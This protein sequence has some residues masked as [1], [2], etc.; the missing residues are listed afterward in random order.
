MLPFMVAFILSFDT[1]GQCSSYALEVQG[2]A[3]CLGNT[4]NMTAYDH[5]GYASFF[6]WYK[7]YPAGN[8]GY[9][10]Q[11]PS[12]S[13]AGYYSTTLTSTTTFGVSFYNSSGGCESGKKEITISPSST[14]TASAR[15]YSCTYG[16]ATIRAT[17][18]SSISRYYLYIKQGN[19]YNQIGSNTTGEFELTN[20][21]ESTP[22]TYPEP[23][24]YYVRGKNSSGCYSHYSNVPIHILRPHAP[25]VSGTTNICS[26]SS[27][28]LTASGGSNG[29]YRWYKGTQLISGATGNQYNTDALV[30]STDYYVTY[31]VQ[32]Y[33][34][35]DDEIWCE[36]PKKRVPVTIQSSTPP[37]PLNKTVC[38]SANVTL[39][40]N[41]STEF[42]QYQWYDQNNNLLDATSLNSFSTSSANLT[43]YKVKVQNSYGC[44]SG[45]SV[46]ANIT[47]KL[48]HLPILSQGNACGGPWSTVN[49]N[50]SYPYSTDGDYY[51]EWY[52]TAT[53]QTAEHVLLITQNDFWGSYTTPPLEQD[54]EYWVAIRDPSAGYNCRT[55]RVSIVAQIGSKPTVSATGYSC[56]NGT[57]HITT[58][59]S[60]DVAT[61][62][63]YEG[64]G[65]DFRSIAINS[66]GDFTVT[67]FYQN[68]GNDH[69]EPSIYYVQGEAGSGCYTDYSNVRLHVLRGISTIT[70]NTEVC[71][72]SSTTLTASGGGADGTYQ[73]YMGS[74][75]IPGATNAQFTTGL[76][77][78]DMDYY[79][80]FEQQVLVGNNIFC[81]SPKR[82]VSISSLIST[83]PE[84]TGLVNRC[85]VGTVAL[86][87]QGEYASVQWYNSAG[88]PISGAT[89][90]NLSI[91]INELDVLGLYKVKGTYSNGCVSDFSE[92]MVTAV[93]NCENFVHEELVRIPGITEVSLVGGLPVD[94][95]SDTWTYLDDLGRPL[96]KV[97]QQ[98]SPSKKDIVEPITYDALGRQ[99]IE[100][101]S[102]S[103]TATTATP[104]YLHTGALTKQAGFYQNAD[105]VAQDTKPWAEKIF[106]PSPLNRVLQQGAAGT[107]WQPH[108]NAAVTTD[109]VIHYSYEVNSGND[110]V[111]LWTID[112]ADQ[113]KA[114]GYYPTGQLTKTVTTDEEGR[115][116][117]EFTDKKENVILKRVQAVVSPSSGVYVLGQWAD[118]YYVFDD[119]GNLRYVFPPE[120]VLEIGAPVTFPYTPGTG[121][122]DRWAFLYTYDGRRRMVEKQVPGAKPV[123][124]V[125]DNRDRLVLTQDGNQ[126]N[127]DQW[128]F[129]KYDVLNRPVATGIYA[130]AVHTT[131]QTMRDWVNQY[132]NNLTTGRAWF[133]SR[134]SVVHGYDNK[135]F[136]QLTDVN[137][138]LVITYYDDYTFPHA[139]SYSFLPSLDHTSAFITV[140]GQVTGIKTKVLGTGNEWME[141]VTYYDDRY[142]VIQS[143]NENLLNTTDIVTNRYDFVGN[144]VATE[145]RHNNHSII[146]TFDY[147]HTGRL[148]DTWHELKKNGISQGRV[149]LAR[150]V[151][152]ELGELVE[153][154][155]HSEDE[156][157]FRQSVDY[158]YNIRGWLTSINN[159]QLTIDAAINDDTDD[160]WG[161]ELGYNNSLSG[162]VST[163]AY[164]GNISAIK[165]SNEPG[166]GQRAY[167]Y[168]YDP[169]NRLEK[170][171]HLV[172]GSANNSDYDVN[173]GTPTIKGYDLNGNIKY[174]TRNDGNGTMDELTYTYSGNILQR[175]EDAIGGAKGFVNGHTGTD[176]NGDYR[177]DDNGN[178]TRDQNKDITG[179]DYN[180]LNLPK[181]VTKADGSYLS[182]L[183][184]ASGVKL[185]QEVY[186]TV[187]T[188]I[189][190]TD[191][192]GEFIYENNELQL[193]QHEEGRIVPDATTGNFDYQYHLKDH[194]G[195]V[196][197]T[198]TT[199][200]KEIIFE[201]NYENDP[202]NVDDIAIFE[203]VSVL[204]MEEFNHTEGTYANSTPYSN[205][206]VLKSSPNHQ[207]GSAI[208]LPVGKGDKI[209]CEVFAKYVNATADPGVPVIGLAAALVNAFTGSAKGLTDNGVGTI[210]GN[211]SSGPLIGSTG[212]PYNNSAAPKAFLNLIFL[213]DAE[214]IDLVKDV[215]FAYDQIA[216]DADETVV[217]D[218]VKDPFDLLQ[219]TD[220]EA[221]GNG[222]VLI[223]VSNEGSLSNVFF[224]DLEIRVN[225][226]VVIQ[227]DDYYPFGLSFDDGY[228]RVTSLK[229]DFTFNGKELQDEL[230]LGWMDYGARMYFPEIGRFPV[231]DRFSEKYLDLTPYQY[232]VNNPVKYI[233]INGDSVWI[234]TNQIV[235]AGIPIARH[236]FLRVKTDKVDKIMELGGPENTRTGI[237]SIA[238]YSKNNLDG[239]SGVEEGI[240]IRPEN[241]P[242]GD[243][244]FENSILEYF[245]FFQQRVI[246]EDDNTDYPN[247]PDYD[248]LGPNSNGF[249]KSLIELS[250]G[251]AELPWSAIGQ[252]DKSEY[253]SVVRKQKLEEVENKMKRLD[254][255]IKDVQKKVNTL[256]EQ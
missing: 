207:I 193:I 188:R 156:I 18:P 100:Y 225:E 240:I 189:K 167:S 182:Y 98:S 140:K 81:E 73:W 52:T 247:L 172:V 79:V 49:I 253:K 135:S 24:E 138:Y 209:N 152:N 86:D 32:A 110:R 2:G 146:R 248:A 154:N 125:Y 44:W 190:R 64:N 128:L 119:L 28:T 82:K 43:S 155:L 198:F 45:Y 218:A 221:P 178:M 47:K 55:D 36:S 106:E 19:T 176:A 254:N 228:R 123:Y 197:L 171:D 41:N 92:V 101:L 46:S 242:E 134:G 185:V 96:Q 22:T 114:T 194:L 42:S 107:A 37:T 25:I 235:R 85:G 227:R 112:P 151:Y 67:D 83:P 187:G 179:I 137:A 40:T 70:G 161:M 21:Y 94:K 201:L 109:K 148:V 219:I 236:A 23:S 15:G 78:K 95:K 58:Q 133:E 149:L 220:F 61:Y 68:D 93:S 181:T 71:A 177:Y 91:T 244:S 33:F 191:Y 118:T 170:A 217:G 111:L 89:N 255:L 131:R 35:G 231:Q 105:K 141:Q 4:A 162:V 59:S 202:D 50:V 226:T 160:H 212:F 147:D 246:D 203:D 210:N 72:G 206:Q 5:S 204:S 97:L 175:V 251:E 74:E 192:M 129:T 57:A 158:R 229:N 213:P 108:P 153:M 27:T 117:I 214:E 7:K 139:N 113:L 205:A 80:S 199:R 165:W 224:D 130:D 9:L 186:D 166:A 66:H 144:I 126:R 122:M 54:K 38:G 120:A 30:V 20:F 249:A 103:A 12:E 69:P 222:Y 174:L 142:R 29:N 127:N 223:Y 173:I 39:S 169:L 250:G 16:N 183:Y 150:N 163:P 53:G 230:D 241:S 75:P 51:M 34:S 1:Y 8:W 252:D 14:L 232:V 159:S 233:D 143:Q 115:A 104:G 3:G 84:V 10:G 102:Y 234:F 65:D 164:N 77:E 31:R 239:R 116:V 88:D 211:F 256:K 200:P 180:H 6:K 87:A 76:I 216:H 60:G 62:T 13:G 243:F 48:Q 168:T 245:D 11:S 136:P 17:S 184:D 132:Y 208:A 26:G 195:N 124:M 145:T 238:N 56:E 63:L 121:L 99:K 215:T 90:S 237:P 196:R 157:A